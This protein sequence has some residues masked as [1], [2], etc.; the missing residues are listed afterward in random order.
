MEVK[1]CLSKIMCN[2]QEKC[3]VDGEYN[4]T[5]LMDL[6]WGRKNHLGLDLNEEPVEKNDADDWP[7]P[8]VKHPQAREYAQLLLY[9]LQWSILQIFQ[10]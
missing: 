8:I 1:N 3:F 7:T 10:C 2:W 9:I 5:K 4:I 6:A